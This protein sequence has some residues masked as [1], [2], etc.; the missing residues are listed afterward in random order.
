MGLKTSDRPHG[1][2]GRL[3]NGNPSGDWPKARRCGAKTRRQ[4]PCQCPAM[5]GAP[6][7]SAARRARERLKDWSAAAKRGGFMAHG[8][9][10]RLRSEP[11]SVNYS[12]LGYWRGILDGSRVGRGSTR[13]PCPRRWGDASAGLNAT[14]R[15]LRVG[16][17]VRLRSCRERMLMERL[18]YNLLLRWFVVWPSTMR[19]E[20]GRPSRRTNKNRW[21]KLARPRIT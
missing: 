21:G 7:V 8:Q 14:V 16:A 12:T 10:M 18:E 5:H 3:R 13:R 2:R 15:W 4:A 17:P 11:H 9:G 6:L 1:R 20:H 19:C